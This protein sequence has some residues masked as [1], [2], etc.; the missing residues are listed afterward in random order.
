MWIHCMRDTHENVAPSCVE[1]DIIISFNIFFFFYDATW[2]KMT[3][4]HKIFTC[5][6]SS[7]ISSICLYIGNI[8][9]IV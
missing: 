3:Q 4:Y 1:S 6:N 2:H 8:N 7:N 9:S 5:I